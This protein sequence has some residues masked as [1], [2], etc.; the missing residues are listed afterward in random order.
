MTARPIPLRP[1]QVSLPPDVDHEPHSPVRDDSKLSAT[2][3]LDRE[4]D[5]VPHNVVGLT[6]LFSV[7]LAMLVGF[8]FLTGRGATR[9]AAIVLAVIAIP[10][11]VSMLRNKA[12]RE[13]DH[14]HPSR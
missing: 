14:I 8:M 12:E 2:E 3:D 10:I 6:A 13:R 4:P 11:L 9:V 1:S 5:G 7:M